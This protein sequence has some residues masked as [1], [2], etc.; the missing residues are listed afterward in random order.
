MIEGLQRKLDEA[1]EAKEK[2]DELL[3]N[4]DEKS[5]EHDSNL[6]DLHDKLEELSDAETKANQYKDNLDKQQAELELLKQKILMKV[7]DFFF[8]ASD[9]IPPDRTRILNSS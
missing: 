6:K 7:C 8:S 4:F 3:K 1:L 2:V 9:I 5:E